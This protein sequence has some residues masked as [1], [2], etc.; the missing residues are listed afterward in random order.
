MPTY[1][2]GPVSVNAIKYDG[3]NYQQVV[4]MCHYA[5][6]KNFANLVLTVPYAKFIIKI[7][8]YVVRYNSKTYAVFNSKDFEKVFKLSGGE[9]VKGQNSN[10][11]INRG[12]RG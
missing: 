5:V 10:G 6:K 4:R 2:S 12:R 7:N 9:D 11:G 1:I 8:D 3:N